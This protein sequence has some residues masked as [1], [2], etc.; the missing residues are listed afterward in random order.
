MRWTAGENDAEAEKIERT[1]AGETIRFSPDA[2]FWVD[3]RARVIQVNEAALAMHGYSREEMLRQT[4]FDLTDEFERSDWEEFWKKMRAKKTLRVESFHLR[5]DGSR[6]PT[7]ETI[8]FVPGKGSRDFAAAFVRDITK[9]RAEEKK[10]REAFAE[11][12]SLKNRLS[13]ENRYLRE[14]IG[15]GGPGPSGIVTEDP[16]FR[17]VLAMAEKVAPTGS[18]VLLSGETG[19]GKEL[20]ARMIHEHSPRRDRPLVKV[21][22]AALPPELIES[23]L[24]GH[25]KGS[26]SGAH[27]ARKGRFE[28][29][30]GGTLFLDEVGELPLDLQSKLL[31]VLQ[32]GEFERVGAS[33]PTR[34]DVRVI[35][36]TNRDLATEVAAGG[37]R[38]DLFYRLDV[39]PLRLPPLRERPDDIPAL[40]RHFIDKH[41]PRVG[42][43]ARD[44]DGPGTERLR[45]Y[46]WPGNVRELENVIE[47]ALILSSGPVLDSSGFPTTSPAGARGEPEGTAEPITLQDLEKQA[48]AEALQACNGTV[49][50]PGGAARRLGLAPSTL[51]D[52]VRRYGL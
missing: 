9:R 12:E 47:R 21:N 20:V 13:E 50:G 40:A 18:T 4:V 43:P 29:A 42:S 19:T 16:G 2:V 49:D 14:E 46:S 6:F 28:I 41:A 33:S 31:R 32:E 23:E 38:E 36:A 44:I 27:A 51:R 39:F 52:R 10:L 11:I 45:D 15:S 35:S 7:D 17:R 34:T 3:D 5:A 22:C 30:D 25:E 37:F 48:I 1:L 26:F 24:F 8:I